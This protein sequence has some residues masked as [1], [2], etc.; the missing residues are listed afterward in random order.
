MTRTKSSGSRLYGR[1]IPLLAVLALAACNDTA[2]DDGGDGGTGG[3]TGGTGGIGGTG[4]DGGSGGSTGGTGGGTSDLPLGATCS[5]GPECA[6]GACVDD[7]CCADACAGTCMACNLPGHLGECWPVSDGDDPRDDCADDITSCLDGACDGSGACRA[8]ADGLA[9]VEDSCGSGMITH[10]TCDAGRCLTSYTACG[11]F[12]CDT[13]STCRTD[14][15]IDDHCKLYYT[16][17]VDICL[18]GPIIDLRADVNRNGTIDMTDPSEDEQEDTW[19]ADHGAIFLANIDDDEYAC[20]TAG[21]DASLA[22]CNDAMDDQI[23]GPDDLLDLARLRTVPWAQAPDDASAILSMSGATTDVVRLFIDVGDGFVPLS[24]PSALSAAHRRA[25]LELAIEGRDVARDPAYWDGYVDLT[26]SVDAGTGP[27]GPLQDGA[28]TVR[29]RVAPMIFRHHLDEGETLYATSFPEYESV[30]FRSG[31]ESAMTAAGVPNP[32]VEFTTINDQ[33]TQDLF[34][35]AYTS[36]PTPDG[37]HIIHVNVRSA[38]FADNSLRYGGRVVFTDLR[39]PDVAGLIHYDPSHNDYWDTLNSFGNMETIPPFTHN[40]TSWPLGRVVRGGAPGTYPDTAFDLMVETQ[41]VQPIVY[42]D[43]SWLLVAHID[44]TISYVR[45]AAGENDWLALISDP[46]AGWEMLSA[47]Q[48]AGNGNAVMFDNLYW[49]QNW[50]AEVTIAETLTDPDLV[51][52]RDWATVEIDDQVIQLQNA[53]GITA[54][55]IVWLPAIFWESYGA[56]VAYM[57]GTANGISV[58]DRDYAAPI[59]HG[60]EI[61]GADIFQT[62]L[63]G[64]LGAHDINV[65]WIENWDLYH[66]LDGEIHCGSNTTRVIPDASLWWEAGL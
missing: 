57:P 15:T 39:G 13:A 27:S 3:S 11:G 31:L 58:G 28:D 34:E 21:S 8:Y 36:M 38:N 2:G 32:L 10:N 33:W 55:D 54:A 41:G 46:V 66:R 26:L 1:L 19:D 59:T 12:A 25:G 62:Q 56:L 24:M 52:A 44:E 53:T 43:T 7:L 18:I 61:D 17:D 16:C 42:I 35:T 23:N 30:A 60:P 48:S 29:L 40:G 37:P 4:G 9:C 5:A 47:E 45:S 65:H 63:E 22:A 49:W 51:N 14:C 64:A 50:P 20:P 6:S